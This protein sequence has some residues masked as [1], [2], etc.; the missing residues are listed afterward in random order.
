MTAHSTPFTS[1]GTF[2]PISDIVS[3]KVT[4]WG[5]NSPGTSN[6]GKVVGYI[7]MSATDT[8]TITI[9]GTGGSASGSTGGTHGT[10]FHN[11]G[12]GANGFTS[13]LTGQGGGGGGGSTAV[14]KGSTLYIEAGGAGASGGSVVST[15]YYG[16]AG[17]KGGKNPTNGAGGTGY[18]AID[19][20]GGGTSGS[21][22]GNGA[23]GAASGNGGSAGSAASAGVG[24]A[25][26][27]STTTQYAGGGGGGGG[28]SYGGGGGGGGGLTSGGGGGGGGTSYASG[29]VTS[30]VFTDGA[31]DGASKVQI[32]Y[33]TADAPLAPTLGAP[34]SGSYQDGAAAILFTWTYNVGTDSGTQSA[35]ALRRK[36]GLGAYGYWNGTDFSS[37]TPVWNTSSVQS[38]SIPASVFTNGNNYSWSVATQESYYSLQGVF[39]SDSLFT[40]QAAP[41]VN[42]TAPT[43][44]IA[45]TAPVIVWST[46]TP[47]GASQ[48]SWRARVFDATNTTVL[49]DSGVQAG[50]ATSASVP[51]GLLGNG[52]YNARVYVTESGGQQ[53]VEDVQSF[54]IF[55]LIPN[56]PSITVV[57]NTSD[58]G[59]PALQITLQGHDNV[60]SSDDASSEL[61]LGGM[62]GLANATLTR[63]NTQAL[64]SSWSVAMTAVLAAT[65]EMAAA[66]FQVNP[67]EQ[68]TNQGAF[69]AGS[70]GRSV[71]VGIMWYTL[72]GG[73]QV[74]STVFGS[75]VSDTSSGWVVA[76]C[77]AT[78]PAGA[79]WAIPVYQVVGAA[80]SEVHYSDE[81]GCTPGTLQSWSAGGFVPNAA[82]YLQR[83]DGAKVRFAPST[84]GNNYQLYTVDDVEV[85]SGQSYTYTLSVS[86]LDPSSNTIQSGLAT[87][88]PASVTLTQWDLSDVANYT[89]FLSFYRASYV[90]GTVASGGQASLVV[91]Q[92]ETQGVFRPLGRTD[93]L[94]THGDMLDEEFDLVIVFTDSADWATF[95]ALRNLQTTLMLRSDL[96]DLYYVSLG[97][98]RPGII[99]RADR[100]APT[101]P[102]RQV[103]VHCY[104]ASRP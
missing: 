70:T 99:L 44:T 56:T 57:P 61:T 34:A 93:Y 14:Q 4:A 21:G 20:P 29:S 33:T 95:N 90:S 104:P 65:M 92:N 19:Q 97:A 87:S 26:G 85:A 48:T 2:G 37:T 39:A 63:S 86:S 64:S 62:V 27:A 23:G 17:G 89:G 40:A 68:W 32:D 8:L 42:I 35:F 77:T 5:G 47:S 94:V 79:N 36:T 52:S 69:R 15:G 80:S 30:A 100:T 41:T 98:T 55:A 84:W 60:L 11:G 71:Q 50:N 83:N 10:G 22:T 24:G 59:V 67:G 12:D 88:G 54:T 28:G 49:W 73:T 58:L 6:P 16:G 25:G 46:T 53:S 76:S 103:T 38:V 9:G 91:D 43:G 96:G 101:G 1:N 7:A 18:S 51:A 75:T 102:T 81:R 3:C 72:N 13:G 82:I 74:G 78:A 45:T 31:S 66:G